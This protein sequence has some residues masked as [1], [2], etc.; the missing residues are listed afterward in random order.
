MIDIHSH[1]LPEVDDGSR[2]IEQ[3]LEMLKEAERQGV[4]DMI[5]TP[6]YR[7]DF[8]NDKKFIEKK[9]AQFKDI[10]AGHGIKIS[11]YIGQEIF[12]FNDMANFLEAGK[13]LSL[14]YGKYVLV[15]FSLKYSMDIPEVVY[16]L[17][18]RGFIPVVAHLCR[19]YYADIETAREIKEVGGLIQINAGSLCGTLRLRRNVFKYIKEGLVDFVASDV[20]YGRENDLGK[21]YKVVDKKFGSVVADRLFTENA[22][23]ILNK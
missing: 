20:H 16:M 11:L 17:K 14:N 9:F 3:S 19:Y 1:V 10:V 13:L 6:H 23:K 4:T 7:T 5:L 18:V 15:E 21:A 8:L 22:K 12:A 2:N